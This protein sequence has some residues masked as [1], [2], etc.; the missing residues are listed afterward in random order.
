M[1]PFSLQNEKTNYCWEQNRT[2]GGFLGD[3]NAGMPS[4]VKKSLVQDIDFFLLS[5]CV[6]ERERESEKEK[7]IER[8]RKWA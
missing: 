4:H 8:E 3:A 1:F 5:A 6:C 2:F 7:R